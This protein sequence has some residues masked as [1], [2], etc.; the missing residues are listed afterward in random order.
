MSYIGHMAEFLLK[1]R[2]GRAILGLSLLLFISL[3][4]SENVSGK[5]PNGNSPPVSVTSYSTTPHSGSLR[6]FLKAA[7]SDSRANELLF[8][9]DPNN[10]NF[11]GP[12]KTARG[13]RVWLT[14][15]TA[16]AFVYVPNPASPRAT[17]YFKYRVDD[18][19][20]FAVSTQVVS[21]AYR[22]MPLGDSITQGVLNGQELPSERVGYRRKLLKLLTA[23]GFKVDFVGSRQNGQFRDAD[24]EGWPGFTARQIANG[25]GAFPGVFEALNRHPANLVLLHIGTNNINLDNVS[26]T[27]SDIELILNEIDRWEESARGNPV[28]VFLARIIDR[29]NT[30]QCPSLNGC[31][32]AKVVALNRKIAGIVSRRKSTGDRVVLV[33]QYGALNY[34]EDMTPKD[35]K[36]IHPNQRG[37]DKMARAWLR[38]I[39]NSGVLR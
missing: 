6:G 1:K 18:P 22:I 12:V 19:E 36:L 26:T 39:Q 5:G 33:N 28:T 21:A 17:D 8:S 34:P 2:T 24:N 15:T 3:D 16:G 7:D 32:N 13:G 27:A 4:A 30:Q 25:S 29:S 11:V 20:S 9:L 10:P 23:N 35:G 37:Y 14:D 31:T 38:A